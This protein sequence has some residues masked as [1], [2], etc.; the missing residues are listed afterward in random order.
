MSKKNEMEITIEGNPAK[1][2]GYSGGEEYIDLN[3]LN[4]EKELTQLL[5]P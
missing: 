2:E 4:G 5:V 1:L 3:V